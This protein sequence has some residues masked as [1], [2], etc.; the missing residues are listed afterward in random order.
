MDIEAELI[1]AGNWPELRRHYS[2]RIGH[3][4]ELGW[5]ALLKDRNLEDAIEHFKDSLRDPHF[6]EA[7]YIIL[8]K[9]SQTRSEKIKLEKP[10]SV[11]HSLKL[12]DAFDQGELRPLVVFVCSKKENLAFAELI[13][14]RVE[15]SK[16]LVR[17]EEL[18]ALSKVERLS[19]RAQL[20][21]AI[22]WDKKLSKPTEAAKSMEAAL[23]EPLL[24]N[25]AKDLGIWLGDEDIISKLSLSYEGKDGL[26][27]GKYLKAMIDGVRAG[28]L[29][30][31]LKGST[32]EG[33]LLALESELTSLS[34]NLHGFSFWKVSPIS[35]RA[36]LLLD[37]IV[38]T[39]KHGLPAF[40]NWTHFLNSEMS[41]FRKWDISALLQEESLSAWQILVELREDLLS[42][43]LLKFPTQ[44]RFLLL[45]SVR[46]GEN[47]KHNHKRW[48]KEQKESD[49]VRANLRRAFERST[50]KVL[51]FDRIRLAGCSQDLYDFI[52]TQIE[53]PMLWILEDLQSQLIE[54]SQT[55]RTYL[56]AHLMVTAP[57][58][59]E[60]HS[61]A[62]EAIAKLLRFLTPNEKQK[63]L[64]SRFVLG[65]VPD[66]LL[67]DDNL[68]LMW[69]ART[70][71]GSEVQVLWHA[72]VL[73]SLAKKPRAS[74]KE[75][76]W[77]WVASGWALDQKYL[78]V[79][80]PTMSESV[81]FPWAQYL[82]SAGTHQAL[83]LL[84]TCLRVIPEEGLKVD[85]CRNL[86]AQSS[87]NRLLV[88]IQTVKD[89]AQRSGLLA[90]WHQR[91]G[92]LEKAFEFYSVQ[93]QEAPILND[94]AIILKRMIEVVQALSGAALSKEELSLA[95]LSLHDHFQRLMALGI[96]NSDLLIG[97]Q[98]LADRAGESEIAFRWALHEWLSSETAVRSSLIDR[99]ASYA[100]RGGKVEEFQKLLVASIFQSA[101]PDALGMKM[102]HLLCDPL[103]N[104]RLQH[105]RREFIER[106]SCIFPLHEEVLKKR[107][108][109]DYR[110]SVLWK[111]FYGSPLENAA[112]APSL[113]SKR[114]IQLWGLTQALTRTE[115]FVALSK[116]IGE[117]IEGV[118]H[119]NFQKD[120]ARVFKKFGVKQA[121]EVQVSERLGR[122]FQVS[123]EPYR[124]SLHP[125]F[126]ERMDD[127]IRSALFSALAQ[128]VHD[129]ERGLYRSDL[130]VERFFQGMLLSDFGIIRVIQFL[131][132]LAIEEGLAVN[133]LVDSNP[134]QL[135][136]NLPFLSHILV[137][138]LSRDFA[139]KSEASGLGYD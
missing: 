39:R 66:L 50:N 135:L 119:E 101:E 40:L 69:E 16:K 97:I 7:S 94:Y 57:N 99:L 73:D 106:A 71:V 29:G 59:S 36:L 131:V 76:H 45:W 43:A 67:E 127:S 89:L 84:L 58:P 48:P 77:N 103:S 111:A 91:R 64:L 56:V 95:C 128:L 139:A 32:R 86:L 60:S 138:F 31:N 38:N 34:E 78:E 65:P 85:W 46:S 72:S 70:R 120:C 116:F 8:R 4:W 122:R 112:P 15:K 123:F 129:R 87:D 134:E 118:P 55:V 80:A 74:L 81:S 125:D 133:G 30:E 33:I 117:S 68:D 28:R 5:I 19:P 109:F 75:R 9:L 93:L 22:L 25:L 44:E 13:L 18:K 102:I 12:F 121:I 96:L 51:W 49:V 126:A 6:E 21:L 24:S 27:A 47:R 52:L 110:A 41:D 132:K 37:G 90:D 115:D 1:R 79:F 53:P 88:S 100:L 3:Q 42:E 137:F 17:E 63:V 105:F 54:N 124:L 20:L 136:K 98:S 113:G 82:E 23:R 108:E 2:H 35:P 11:P 62:P 14:D 83:N 10:S 26:L 92:E 104:F 61:L 130:L 114:E 107:T